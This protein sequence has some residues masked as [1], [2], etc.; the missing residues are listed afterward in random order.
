MKTSILLTALSLA[1][2]LPAL[3]APKKTEEPAAKPAA[4]SE[5]KSTG[6]AKA[7]KNTYPLYGQVVSCNTRTLTIKGGEGKEDRKYTLNADT[8][9]TKGDKPAT[10]DDVKEGQWVGGLLEK[11][12]D[13]NDKVVKLN[14]SV[15]QKAAKPAAKEGEATK[16]EGKTK[17]KA[18]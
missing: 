8:V 2:A 17:K 16:T 11:S 12:T 4:K 18:E 1:F 13:G 6:E 5:A 15:K 7:K 3:A 10:S 9:I 14:L